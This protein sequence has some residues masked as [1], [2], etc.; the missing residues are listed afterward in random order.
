M[1]P[2]NTPS[3]HTGEEN[4]AFFATHLLGVIKGFQLV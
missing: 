4:A 2:V 1:K 3:Y